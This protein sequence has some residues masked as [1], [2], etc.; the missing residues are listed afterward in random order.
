MDEGSCIIV[1]SSTALADGLLSRLANPSALAAAAPFR[2]RFMTKNLA[3]GFVCLGND[4]RSGAASALVK[5]L[6][7]ETEPLPA[8]TVTLTDR[9]RRR[10]R[11]TSCK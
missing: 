8:V 3:A 1:S 9:V 4:L 11:V 2:S 7:S 6:T 10:W 5:M